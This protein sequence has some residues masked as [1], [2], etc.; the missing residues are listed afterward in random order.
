MHD[1]RAKR[2]EHA[3]LLHGGEALKS[4]QKYSTLTASEKQQLITFLE[5]L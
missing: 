3:I 4:R 5:S 2:I 1:G